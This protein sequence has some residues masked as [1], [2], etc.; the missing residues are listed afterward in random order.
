MV[1]SQVQQPFSTFVFAHQKVR[2][3][4]K[5]PNQI[6]DIKIIN[7]DM[8]CNLHFRL[9]IGKK[10]ENKDRKLQREVLLT[11]NLDINKSYGD[12]N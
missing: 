8:C 6:C 3:P 4:R 1:I 5:V 12:C 9:R 10:V 2:N 7:S 11:F